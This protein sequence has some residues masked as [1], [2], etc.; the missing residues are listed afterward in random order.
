MN[1]PLV[2][3]SLVV[4]AAATAL[5]V[6]GGAL[7]ALWFA[8]CANRWRGL[9]LAAAVAALVL[10]PFLVVNCW[11][12][13]L[14]ENGI[15]RRWLPVNIY[16]LGGAIWVLALLNWPI[17]FLFVSAAWRRVQ[18]AHL[19]V[20]P[21]LEGRFLLRWLLL[22]LARTALAQSA[23]LILVLALNNFS[24]PAILQVKV[25]PAEV[26]VRFN[27]T[28]DYRS[29]LELSWPLVLAPLILVLCLRGGDNAWSMPP[30][31]G[32]CGG[33]WGTPG[34]AA[35][36]SRRWRWRAFRWE[37]RSGSWLAVPRR[38]SNFGR[39]GW[40]A[41]RPSFIPSDTPPF[42]P[43]LWSRW[44]CGRGGRGRIPCCGCRS[45]YPAFCWASR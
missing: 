30:P 28:F 34:I 17:A 23:I 2:C 39:H 38:G 40:R 42:P 27:T 19:E 41:N 13:L 32:R 6:A 11:I 12:E 9:F 8:G 31:R 15:W 25:F 10:P 20:D 16:T 26:W 14:G 35:G 33:N 37:F 43:P 5:A 36:R 24:V 21:L 7:A 45:S 1:W 3:N 29:A 4:S 22:P 18:A 44:R